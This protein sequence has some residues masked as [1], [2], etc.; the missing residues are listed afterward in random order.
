MRQIVFDSKGNN[1]MAFDQ[2]SNRGIGFNYAQG[3]VV[4]PAKPTP[5]TDKK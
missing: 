2:N 1:G 3:F 5:K 4:P